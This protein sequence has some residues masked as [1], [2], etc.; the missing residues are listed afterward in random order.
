[1]KKTFLNII[2]LLAF[3]SCSHTS[4]YL[5]YDQDKFAP[6]PDYETIYSSTYQQDISEGASRSIA[7][8]EDCIDLVDKILK[9]DDP[10]F[11]KKI[12]E[13]PFVAADAD[14]RV[15]KALDKYPVN[16]STKMR[17]FR[18]R[19]LGLL[20]NASQ[21]EAIIRSF[22]AAF[23]IKSDLVKDG[24]LKNGAKAEYDLVIVGTGVHGVIALQEA[25]A[26][27]PN[28]RILLI[29]EGDTAGATFRYGKEVFS[30]NSSSR[31]SGA[32]SRPLPGEGNINEL[33][34]FPIQVSDLTGVKYPTANDLG[35]SIVTGLYAA[36]REHPNVDVVF[37]TKAKELSKAENATNPD[38]TVSVKLSSIDDTNPMTIDAQKVILT[39]GL[40][41]SGVPVKIQ[42]ALALDAELGKFV[43]GKIPLIVNFEDI[44]RILAMSN[45]PIKLIKDK[46][47]GIVGKGDSANVLIE[48][49]LGYAAREGYAKST[50]QDGRARKIFWIGQDKQDCKEFIAK[51][52]SRYQG[53]STGF[54]SSSKDLEAI[55]TPVRERIDNVGRTK[56]GKVSTVLENGNA[57]PEVD[58]VILTTGFTPN[59]RA[60]FDKLTSGK[61]TGIANDTEFF[62][63]DF[64]TLI[65]PTSTSVKP[66]KVGRKYEEA[67]VYA[68][69]TAA[70]QLA[71][72]DELVGIV[73][74]FVSIFN[75]APRVVAAVAQMMSDFSPSARSFKAS[76][77]LVESSTTGNSSFK[78][79][80]IQE[81]RT[82]GEQTLPY[83]E[84][85]FK[86]VL[87]F[88]VTKTNTQISFKVSLNKDGS[89]NV[90][91][92]SSLDLTEM[93]KLMAGTREFF[94]LSREAL[95]IMDGKDLVFTA[96]TFKKSPAGPYFSY[97]PS[98]ADL[99]VVKNNDDVNEPNPTNINNK[100][101]ELRGLKSKAL[102]KSAQANPNASS[103]ADSSEIEIV[104]FNSI[105]TATAFEIELF[106]IAIKAAKFDYFNFDGNEIAVSN[107][108]IGAEVA[109]YT[110]KAGT[111]RPFRV[112]KVERYGGLI[113][114]SEGRYVGVRELGNGGNINILKNS[115][116]VPAPVKVDGINGKNEFSIT[117]GF[118]SVL[119]SLQFQ[120]QDLQ[121]AF[122]SAT[123]RVYLKRKDEYY[124][125]KAITV[126]SN[127]FEVDNASITSFGKELVI[128]DRDTG[129][130]FSS[131][132]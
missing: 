20:K 65:A 23:R 42:A 102:P 1:M 69:G 35:S 76:K 73:Q 55:I 54:R 107:P 57:G 95:K 64:E 15:K 113:K 2:V 34:G 91:S 114:D 115:I 88:V 112:V 123:R 60:L 26:K 78:I 132:D 63:S 117:T 100:K 68:F 41:E 130:R 46:N 58:F 21:R 24:I 3:I 53:I 66:T 105:K 8:D 32:G 80:G 28:L 5:P 104:E 44:L 48:F 38:M 47:I 86:E 30:I 79:N 103:S 51:I 98:F 45:D 49:L 111:T 122:D 89:L 67:E 43:E 118:Q 31:A 61:S 109:V 93:L 50:A 120:G 16:M 36:L 71:S 74:N 90:L 127:R 77:I 17:N 96:N 84:S 7:N 94:S 39:T 10:T 14:A 25:L 131:E 83:L 13:D 52:R 11:V 119:D 124:P 19:F 37:Q 33:P 6:T 128:R 101:I 106:D 4:V 59:V 62:E 70:G 129:L 87:S 56:N 22:E 108:I 29:D 125:Y 81:S 9:L 72:D 82:M 99:R 116:V 18:D 27:N 121:Y 40:G 12:K 97:D 110:R 92:N 85:V 75:N 126:S